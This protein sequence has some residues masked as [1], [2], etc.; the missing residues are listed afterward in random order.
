MSDQIVNEHIAEVAHGYRISQANRS[1]EH[2]VNSR[3]CPRCH[4]ANNGMTEV[5][6]DLHCLAC[7][8]VADVPMEAWDE[9]EAQKDALIAEMKA[10]SVQTISEELID[11]A[12]VALD[13]LEQ[14]EAALAERDRMLRQAWENDDKGAVWGEPTSFETWLDSLRA[15]AE[16]GG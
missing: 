3:Q 2:A 14:A 9:C 13:L 11:T 5:A 15:R 10:E 7:G 16:E 1:E 12:E 6:G 4:C 8:Y